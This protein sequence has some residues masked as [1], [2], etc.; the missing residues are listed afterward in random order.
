MVDVSTAGARGASPDPTHTPPQEP[1]HPP[2]STVEAPL[3][4]SAHPSPQ[5]SPPSPH[6]PA[7]EET[8]LPS[9][10]TPVVETPH[11]APARKTG[12]STHPTSGVGSKEG[13]KKTGSF[14]TLRSDVDTGPLGH[15]VYKSKISFSITQRQRRVSSEMSGG[16]HIPEDREWDDI[17]LEDLYRQ[18]GGLGKCSDFF[19]VV[20]APGLHVAFV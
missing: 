1:S 8:P 6:P 11:K 13:G 9:S 14:T 17:R 3:E 7:G 4:D 12:V 15:C 10:P 5:G 20:P 18:F 2:P 16:F 19:I